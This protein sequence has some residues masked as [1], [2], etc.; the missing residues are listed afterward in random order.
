MGMHV[1]RQSRS[2]S[3]Q[4]T[5][6]VPPVPGSPAPPPA[7]GM[8]PIPPSI[9]VPPTPFPVSPP[10]PGAPNVP[11]FDVLDVVPSPPSPAVVA[12]P[13]DEFVELPL[14]KLDLEEQANASHPTASATHFARPTNRL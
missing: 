12:V 3:P 4:A 10:M 11:P 5:I 9:R 6:S 13:P 2:S 1:P 7:P 14:P 8:P